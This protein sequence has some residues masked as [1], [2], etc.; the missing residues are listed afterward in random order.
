[1]N[2]KRRNFFNK[3]TFLVRNRSCPVPSCTPTPEALSQI[4]IDEIARKDWPPGKRCR[5]YLPILSSE[6]KR[7]KRSKRP[8]IK[9]FLLHLQKSPGRY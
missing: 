9:D 6:Q 5:H 7:V 2:V 8:A 3:E 4:P 1:M